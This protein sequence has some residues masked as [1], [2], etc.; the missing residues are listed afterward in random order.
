MVVHILSCWY[1][2]DIQEVLSGVL[3]ASSRRNVLQVIQ[4]YLSLVMVPALTEGQKWGALHPTQVENFLSSL[5][6]HVDF[7]RGETDI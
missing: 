7:L 3:D 4:E 2:T 6:S 1:S 5:Q